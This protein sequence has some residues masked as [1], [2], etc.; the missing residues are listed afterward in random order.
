MY[1]YAYSIRDHQILI[2]VLMF[3]IG[4]L[5]NTAMAISLFNSSTAITAL[6]SATGDRSQSHP[7]HPNEPPLLPPTQHTNEPLLLGWMQQR[8]LTASL[9]C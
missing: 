4:V 9:G 6:A 1:T 5:G 8:L 2:N 3:N 7:K